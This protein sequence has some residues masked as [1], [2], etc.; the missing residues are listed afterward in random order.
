MCKTEAY[1]LMNVARVLLYKLCEAD[2]IRAQFTLPAEDAALTGVKKGQV[3]GHLGMELQLKNTF[4]TTY[5]WL[6]S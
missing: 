1:L 5:V 4:S 3:L 2:V 6:Y